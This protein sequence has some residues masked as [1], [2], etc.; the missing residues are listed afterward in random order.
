[1]KPRDKLPAPVDLLRLP[2]APCGKKATRAIEWDG[3]R[4]PWCDTCYFGYMGPTER[5]EKIYELA[6][7]LDM[8]AGSGDIFACAQLIALKRREIF[9]GGG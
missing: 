7:N 5:D 1:M 2:C 3:H 4:L 6:R 9:G 8:L